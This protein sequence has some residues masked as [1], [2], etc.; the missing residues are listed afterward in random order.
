MKKRS[1]GALCG[2]V[3]ARI[4]ASWFL[5]IALTLVI[6]AGDVSYIEYSIENLRF[7]VICAVCAFVV[8]SAADVIFARGKLKTPPDFWC[9]F[10]SVFILACVSSYKFM[11]IF[12]AVGCFVAV[13]AAAS[14]CMGEKG[15]KLPEISLDKKT[16]VWLTSAVGAAVFAFVCAV[17]LVRYR[18]YY[19]PTYDFGIF[20]NMFEN[21]IST[22][23]P[24]T[25]CERDGLLS[26]FAVHISPIFYLLLPLYAI[27][28]RAETL[29]IIQAAAVVSGC[30]PVF[31]IARKKLG[32]W[33]AASV[34]AVIYLLFPAFSCGAFFD[35]H[36][37]KLLAPL[38]LWALWFC[39]EKKR[40]P[41]SLFL[42]LTVL[43]KEDAPVYT[44][45]IGAYLFFGKKERI[46][47][48]AVV[49]GS[50]AYFLGAVALLGRIGEG[51]QLW[52]YENIASGSLTAIIGAVILNPMRV[53]SECVGEEKIKFIFQMLFPLLGLPL[54]CKKPSRLVLLV[55][56]LLVNLMPDYVYQHDIGYQ[57]TYGSGALLVYLAV[58]NWADI[59]EIVV[60]RVWKVCAGAV[61]TATLLSFMSSGARGGMYFKMAKNEQHN[62]SAIDSALEVIPKDAEVSASTMFVA[63][64]ADRPVIYDFDD[65]A[66]LADYVVIDLRGKG[67]EETE[68]QR[69]SLEAVGYREVVFYPESAVVFKLK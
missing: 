41:A 6:F 8:F 48:G 32:S 56:F 16:S 53:V 39:E 50:V 3:C 2:C 59:R 43:V 42:L 49:L 28:P 18:A 10:G 60:P 66:R 55:P 17:C 47:G 15:I 38:I 37:N 5:A 61:L 26:H 57:Y 29:L 69:R 31:L 4:A 25:T 65:N 58:V 27:C 45:V 22:G 20:A 24:N 7:T 36:E 40:L 9:L 11:S 67:S 14:I 35:F 23:L 46:F 12:F 1:F 33:T 44:A 52:R 64:L 30:I 62:I 19:A 68:I 51:A 21:M 13:I 63:H 54:V 34:F